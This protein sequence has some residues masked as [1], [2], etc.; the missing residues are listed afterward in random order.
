MQSQKIIV[1]IVGVLTIAY[2]H[3][4]KIYAA[5]GLGVVI[6]GLVGRKIV[7]LKMY[8]SPAILKS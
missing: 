1:G 3:A 2:G 8:A 4:L 6:N 7:L 5:A